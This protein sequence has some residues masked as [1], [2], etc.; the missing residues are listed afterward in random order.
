MA[1]KRTP[2]AA[3]VPPVNEET[4]VP[5]VVESVVPPVVEPVVPPVVEPAN[6]A[7]AVVIERAQGV[8]Q[9]EPCQANRHYCVYPRDLANPPANPQAVLLDLKRRYPSTGFTYFA[10]R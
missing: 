3:D 8:E 7:D 2:A 5:P 9:K 4:A 6:G 10:N 1:T